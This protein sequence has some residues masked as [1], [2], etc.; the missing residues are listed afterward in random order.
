MA[1]LREW[2]QVDFA[3]KNPALLI[4]C[5]AFGAKIQTRPT[6]TRRRRR[7]SGPGGTPS[8]GPGPTLTLALRSAAHS[9][10][11]SIQTN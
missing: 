7:S 1:I 3:P 5:C 6:V 2:A 9:P 8:H 11:I 4:F 10:K